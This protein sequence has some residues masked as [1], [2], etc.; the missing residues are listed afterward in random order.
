MGML[1]YAFFEIPLLVTKVK[2]E[3]KVK[4]EFFQV[5][6]FLMQKWEKENE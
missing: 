2:Y 6:P 5:T 3:K 4:T 1:F